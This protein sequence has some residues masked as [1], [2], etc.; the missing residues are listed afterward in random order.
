[1]RLKHIVTPI[2]LFATAA[3]AATIGILLVRRYTGQ[4]LT[5]LSLSLQS[6][7]FVFTASAGLL[8]LI[9]YWNSV[10]AEL[11]HKRWKK[12][13]HLE[14]SFHSF[15]ERHVDVIPAFDYPHI[16]R[17]EYFPLCEKAIEYDET[18]PEKQA[19]VFTPG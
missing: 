13:N 1:M 17:K 9:K 8:I 7:I 12:L 3:S 15:R 14:T 18:E 2:L 4:E 10:E 6:V 11:N 5:E 16:L 19:A